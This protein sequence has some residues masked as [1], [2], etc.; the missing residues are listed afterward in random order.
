MPPIP[1][2]APLPDAPLPDAQP[3]DPANKQEDLAAPANVQ[4]FE[5]EAEA[6]AEFVE[7]CFL[8]MGTSGEDTHS[9]IMTFAQCRR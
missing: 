4:P 5:V 6:I 9:E 1:P 7:W 2:D 3:A 8:D